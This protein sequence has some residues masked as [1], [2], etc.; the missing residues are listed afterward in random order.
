MKLSD[1]DSGSLS[2]RS[3]SCGLLNDPMSANGAVQPR[4]QLPICKPPDL[5]FSPSGCADPIQK[6]HFRQIRRE[7]LL[8]SFIFYSWQ[9][10][11]GVDVLLL[12]PRGARLIATSYISAVFTQ[13][14]IQ[15]NFNLKF[16]DSVTQQ[17]S[18]AKC[19]DLRGGFGEMGSSR[20]QIISKR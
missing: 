18:S 10:Q 4:L 5:R 9:P 16:D 15:H 11:L 19:R 1:S 14:V 6:M 13:P 17:A 20:G 3:A 12:E 8:A 7:K 2:G